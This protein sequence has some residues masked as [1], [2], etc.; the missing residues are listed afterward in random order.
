MLIAHNQNN[1]MPFYEYLIGLQEEPVSNFLQMR[2][3]VIDS[4]ENPKHKLRIFLGI[5]GLYKRGILT[6]A[7]DLYDDMFDYLAN[8]KTVTQKQALG[9]LRLIFNNNIGLTMCPLKNIL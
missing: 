8:V 5:C 9:F 7:P 3:S 4:E 2:S 1:P 6:V